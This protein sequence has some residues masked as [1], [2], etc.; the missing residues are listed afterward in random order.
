MRPPGASVRVFSNAPKGVVDRTSQTAGP[1]IRLKLYALAYVESRHGIDASEAFAWDALVLYC[2]AAIGYVAALEGNK[3]KRELVDP[4]IHKDRGAH[5]ERTMNADRITATRTELKLA[6]LGYEAC[7]RGAD[8]YTQVAV[9]GLAMVCQ[10][11]IR[12]VEALEGPGSDKSHL[13]DRARLEE[14]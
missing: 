9:S 5:N 10:A 14:G 3:N 7:R 2:Q 1:R 13:V 6:A 12:Y 11:A 4:T 8:T